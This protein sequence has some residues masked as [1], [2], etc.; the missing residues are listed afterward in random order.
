MPGR[1]VDGCVGDL[2]DIAIEKDHLFSFLRIVMFDW[3]AYAKG[4]RCLVFLAVL[5]TE[6]V[7]NVVFSGVQDF[8]TESSQS[9]FGFLDGIFNND[10]GWCGECGKVDIIEHSR[11]PFCIGGVSGFTVGGDH[12]CVE[13]VAASVEAE[14]P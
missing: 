12:D 8:E 1:L 13:V 11:G 6:V 14:G 4:V 10:V 7:G 9:F 2:V 3:K 5:G